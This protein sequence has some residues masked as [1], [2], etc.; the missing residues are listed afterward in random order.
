VK[1][2]LNICGLR[3]NRIPGFYDPEYGWNPLLMLEWTQFRRRNRRIL[4]WVIIGI[5]TVYIAVP[6]Y[7]GFSTMRMMAPAPSA[8][9]PKY[10]YQAA[11]GYALETLFS[12][13]AYTA[14]LLVL[15]PIL[16]PV[17]DCLTR[18]KLDDLP[19]AWSYEKF[20]VPMLW[21][22]FPMFLAYGVLYYY[23][24]NATFTHGRWNFDISD[25]RVLIPSVLGV[26][27]AGIYTFHLRILFETMNLP[28]VRFLFYGIFLPTLPIILDVRYTAAFIEPFNPWCLWC[29]CIVFVIIDLL[30]V[31]I[32]KNKFIEYV[33]RRG[34][35]LGR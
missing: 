1:S 32:S 23:L 21:L 28:V 24:W 7:I 18:K 20:V 2:D 8:I 4:P 30:L 26:I 5:L 12:L 13:I 14:P 31:P 35:K 16:Y 15:Y 29:F 27:L 34:E 19:L 22:R 25:A 6:L 3:I 9:L 11:F 33:W 17:P 10:Y